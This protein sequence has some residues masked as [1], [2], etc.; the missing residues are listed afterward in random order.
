MVKGSS[1]G[2]TKSTSWV[3]LVAWY[4]RVL[5]SHFCETA[6]PAAPCS[7]PVGITV[8][9]DNG[10]TAAAQRHIHYHVCEKAVCMSLWLNLQGQEIIVAAGMQVT[11]H[12][13]LL[14]QLAIIDT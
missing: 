13:H 11:V 4:D 8:S 1:Q 7:N 5:P 14:M 6:Y 9:D 12:V 10:G 2:L 3:L